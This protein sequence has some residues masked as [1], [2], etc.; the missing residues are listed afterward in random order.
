M[1]IIDYDNWGFVQPAF[2]RLEEGESMYAVHNDAGADG[3][4]Y[5]ALTSR[6]ILLGVAD[7]LR[8]DQILWVERYGSEVKIRAKEGFVTLL[9]DGEHQANYAWKIIWV[10]RCGK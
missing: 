7:E 9:F 6:R 10:L 2:R 5:I 8:W 3:L 4:T 1:P